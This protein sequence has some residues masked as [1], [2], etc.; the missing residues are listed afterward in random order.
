MPQKPS[1]LKKPRHNSKPP[2]VKNVHDMVGKS[3]QELTV[4][5][6]SKSVMAVQLE[7]IMKVFAGQIK[8][9]RWKK[10]KKSLT[11]TFHFWVKLGLANQP[12]PSV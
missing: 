7:A 4:R 10:T 11:M 5:L 3:I 6:K 2:V 8:C 9:M 1:K 12:G